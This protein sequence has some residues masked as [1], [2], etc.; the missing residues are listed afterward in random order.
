MA[1]IGSRH[2][3]GRKSGPPFIQIDR[4]LKRSQIW[5]ELR[6]PARCVLIELI[7]R[8]TGINNGMIALSVRTVADELSCSR[9]TASRAL[10]E[11]DDAG[12]I[13]PMQVG[14]WQGRKATTWRLTF[15][16]CD[17]TGDLPSRNWSPRSQSDEKD[18]K[19]RPEGRNGVRSPT[20]RTQKPKSSISENG[21]SPTT[22]TLIDI[23]HTPDSSDAHN[24]QASESAEPCEAQR[25]S[26][27]VRRAGA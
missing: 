10:R 25:A 15:R 8:Y 22:G 17:V 26:E 21:H 20:R 18:T 13:R 3:R 1:S 19:V 23:Y 5:H 12:F 9:D 6:L 11:L 14:V 27:P 24:N 4:S 7:D 2:R 16:R